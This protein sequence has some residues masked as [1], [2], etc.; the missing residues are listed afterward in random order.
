MVAL[1]YSTRGKPE[2]HRGRKKDKEGEK[3]EKREQDRQT[4]KS[5]KAN[6]NGIRL[7]Q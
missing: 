2:T 4:Q 7:Q 3:E 6:E 1:L 5:C